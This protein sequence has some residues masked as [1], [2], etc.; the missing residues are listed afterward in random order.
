MTGNDAGKTATASLTVT[1]GPTAALVLSPASTTIAAGASQSY[2]AQGVDSYSNPTG[3]VTSS[4]VFS[5]TPD[6]SCTAAS[7]TAN[8]AGPHTVTGNYS[9]KTGMASLTVT[10]GDFA[11]LQ[12][13]V[14]GETAAP[15]TASG[16]T[17]TPQTEYVNGAFNVTVNAVD[18]NWNVVSS[19]TD[20]VQITSTD[21]QA[22]LPSNA[23][24]VLGTGTF[25]VTL[26]TESHDP[27]TTTLTASDV[28]DGTKASDTSP[29]ITVIVA[30]TAS[31]SPSA[32]SDGASTAYTLTVYNA[33]APN[34]NSLKS[35]TVAIP[36]L[37]GTPSLV[38]VTRRP[39]R[40]PAN[41]SVD[42]T[43]LPS[44]L[45]FT[46]ATQRRCRPW[47]NIAIQFTT[48][49]N[50]SI[51]TTVVQEVWTTTAF[52][53][54]DYTG[55]LP[56]AGSE[57]TVTIGKAPAITSTNS[58]SFTVGVAGT[59]TVTTTGVPKSALS[60]SGALPNGV[61]FTDNGDG[62]GTLS[63][64]P[65]TGTAGTYHITF[66][67][68]NGI[69]PDATQA[70]TL[71]VINPATTTTLA[72]SKN[73][74]T[75]GDTVTFTATVSFDS[76]AGTPNGT[77]Q[78]KTDGSALGA[79]VPVTSCGANK[80][81]ATSIGISTLTVPSHTITA[82]YG[83]DTVF[84]ASTGSLTQTVNQATPT[85]NVTGGTFIYDG[86]PHPA[87]GSVTGVN[88]SDLG[89]PTFTYNGSPGAPVNAALTR[90]WPH[91]PETRTTEAPRPMR[92]SRSIRR[93]PQSCSI[94]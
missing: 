82:D 45:R 53:N 25:S 37:G 23:A 5:I 89:T 33:A 56:L 90:W 75:Y 88:G 19:V 79:P 29:A 66:T 16:K 65:T 92:I 47:R 27:A 74:S 91:S 72:S 63:G 50:E 78:F 55:P 24:L 7:C 87:T 49:A 42:L 2:T 15:G 31:I 54:A 76:S 9:G 22:H 73:P 30:Y 38:S 85:V 77:V 51:T 35:V 13:L 81:C 3:D 46:Q 21:A 32:A 59:F 10:A 67:A 26:V 86:N 80:V 84:L 69:P 43:P 57:P 64:T 44:F 6:G 12:L 68:T 14:P 11:K 28:T 41:W 93:R 17:G 61:T 40:T 18:A 71:T 62:T 94:I 4:T 58:V 20:T 70:F 8:I 83:A 52:S 39:G 60:K 34:T 36:T 48:T 1:P